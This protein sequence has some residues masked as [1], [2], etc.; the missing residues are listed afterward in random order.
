MAVLSSTIIILLW[1]YKISVI[2]KRITD[3]KSQTITITNK[4]SQSN[5]TQSGK[6]RI[7]SNDTPSTAIPVRKQLLLQRGQGTIYVP[8]QPT[9]WNTTSIR[10]QRRT[11]HSHIHTHIHKHTYPHIHTHIE[12]EAMS[13][14]TTSIRHQR[15]KLTHRFTVD[16]S[17]SSQSKKRDVPRRISHCGDNIRRRAR[18]LLPRTTTPT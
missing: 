5:Q 14:N 15:R 4:R 1:T 12:R 9:S 7:W 16:L 3:E 18:Q 10:H 6:A 17:V 13:R 8:R 2:W 11:T